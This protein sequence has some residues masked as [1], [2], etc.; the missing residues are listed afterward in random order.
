LYIYIKWS[1][2]VT[3]ILPELAKSIRR[4][5]RGGRRDGGGGRK[6]PHKI[7]KCQEENSKASGQN[8]KGPHIYSHTYTHPLTHTPSHTHTHGLSSPPHHTHTRIHPHIPRGPIFARFVSL[9]LHFM[10]A[11]EILGSPFAPL[12]CVKSIPF[13]NH[14]PTAYSTGVTGMHTRS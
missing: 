12:T 9:G 10:T 6:E 1:Q 7:P 3:K 14:A 2:K 4:G 11:G 13:S 8:P 5:E